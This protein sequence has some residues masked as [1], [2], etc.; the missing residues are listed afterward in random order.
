MGSRPDFSISAFVRARRE[1][2]K[3]GG[4]AEAWVRLHEISL[5][6]LDELAERVGSRTWSVLIGSPETG[7]GHQ[8][9]QMRVQHLL[10]SAQIAGVALPAFWRMRDGRVSISYALVAH[11]VEEQRA[12]RLA[13][14]LDQIVVVHVQRIPFEQV[15]VVGAAGGQRV[16]L[17][18]FEP[19]AIGDMLVRMVGAAAFA[20]EYTA[21]GW[22]EGLACAVA[23]RRLFRP[24]RV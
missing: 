13:Q 20:V 11:E 22:F 14:R 10:G 5:W 15:T 24:S 17:G 7:P 23:E 18:Q 16:A 3:G 4:P 6:R 8:E 2:N 12:L 19:A 9:A 21:I 1:V